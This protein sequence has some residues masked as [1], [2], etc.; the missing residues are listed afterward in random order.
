MKSSPDTHTVRRIILI[1]LGTSILSGGVY[2]ASSML[3]YKMGFPLDDAWIHQVYA[4]NLAYR[5]EWAFLPGQVSGGSTSPLWSVLLAFGYWLKL[6]PFIWTYILGIICLWGIAI[7]GELGMRSVLR[8]YNPPFPWVG[9]VLTLE[10]H[11]AWSS[12]SGMETLLFCLVVFIV[13]VE[14]LTGRNRF[15]LMGLLAGLSMWVRPDG[16]TLLGPILLQ[17]V[18]TNSTWHTR[19]G[20]VI[21]TLLS[22]LTIASFYWLFNLVVTGS[23]FPNTLYAKQAE[24]YSLLTNPFLFRLGRVSLP[25]L[26]GILILM[27]PGI[28]ICLASSIK[29]R[30][31]VPV[32]VVTWCLGFLCLYAWKL[33]VTYQYGRYVVPVLPP[34]LFVG[35][36]GL[37]GFIQA[38]TRGFRWI[39][40]IS[41]RLSSGIVLGV[42]WLLGARNFARDVSII[43][44]EMVATAVWIADHLPAGS[45][46]A[47][48]DI[49]ALGFFG[50]HELV[51]L[52]GLVSPEVIP[53]L[54]DETRLASYLDERKVAYLVTFP[55]WYTSLASGL[56]VIYST[57]APYASML[58]EK[59]MTVYEWTG[60]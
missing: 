17:A 58:G 41:W 55:D 22:F 9:V 23:A 14:V 49:G 24:Y 44:S 56:K 45:L 13:L 21:K 54:R 34:L 5:F 50:G 46:V 38:T 51:D 1:L 8:A 37:I 30:N 25:I 4:R 59:N 15:M 52:A 19:L 47:A 12:V 10:W 18:I 36:K 43:E 7:V 40:S 57:G 39:L 16:I 28:I 42:F 33:P 35:F 29:Q 60:K 26:I 53:F 2:L 27:I 32:L 48:H 6:S 31:W 11:L 20:A 3:F